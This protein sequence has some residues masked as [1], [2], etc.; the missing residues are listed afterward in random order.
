MHE[1]NG[2]DILAYLSK[3]AESETTNEKVSEAL[4]F[5]QMTNSKSFKD[6]DNLLHEMLKN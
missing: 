1:Y 3:V 2:K 6:F 5:A 4:L